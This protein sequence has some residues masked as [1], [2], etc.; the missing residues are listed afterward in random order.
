MKI[1][2][3]SWKNPVRVRIPFCLMKLNLPP[4]VAFPSL[5]WQQASPN[6][7]SHF[8]LIESATL[9]PHRY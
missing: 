4:L 2:N 7:E 9:N 5:H 3:S 6:E 1:T 8:T